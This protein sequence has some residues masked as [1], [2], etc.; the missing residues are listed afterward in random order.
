VTAVVA[1]ELLFSRFG[2]S[3]EVAL[4]EAVL[5]AVP[6]TIGFATTVIVA[7]E[8]LARLPSE[9]VTVTTSFA[10][11]ELQVPWVDLTELRAAFLGST[12]AAVTPD[13]A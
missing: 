9:Q 10:F 8:P 3:G 12:S 5:V 1:V 11:F 2:S 13:A 6:I 7:D 4:A